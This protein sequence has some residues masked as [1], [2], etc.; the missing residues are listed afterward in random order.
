MNAYHMVPG[1][2]VAVKSSRDIRKCKHLLP[3][4]VQAESAFIDNLPPQT[5]QSQMVAFVLLV[6]VSTCTAMDHQKLKHYVAKRSAMQLCGESLRAALEVVCQH[7]RVK[8]SD[9]GKFP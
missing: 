4:Y 7:N 9:I 1:I 2:W 8:R 6:V 5:Y 3:N